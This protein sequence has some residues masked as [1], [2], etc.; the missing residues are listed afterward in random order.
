MYHTRR[1][2]L[3][4]LTGCIRRAHGTVLLD[5][6][7]P[8]YHVHVCVVIITVVAIRSSYILYTRTHWTS[9]LYMYECNFETT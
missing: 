9:N 6:F 8:D 7:I 1:P 3:V 5:V 2:S 4:N